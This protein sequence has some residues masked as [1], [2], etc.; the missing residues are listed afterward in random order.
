MQ[1]WIMSVILSQK[2][3]QLQ[4]K[5]CFNHFQSSLTPEWLGGFFLKLFPKKEK[6]KKDWNEALKGLAEKRS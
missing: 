3:L 2:Q 4:C 6:K 1:F 5:V